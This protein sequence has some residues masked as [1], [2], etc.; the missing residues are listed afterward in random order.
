MAPSKATKCLQGVDSI[1]QTPRGHQLFYCPVRVS[2]NGG[3]YRGINNNGKN[4]IKNELLKK[5]V[6]HNP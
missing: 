3:G 2:P 4:I 5:R 1:H 6:S